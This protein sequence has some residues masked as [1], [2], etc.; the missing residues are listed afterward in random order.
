MGK[1]KTNSKSNTKVSFFYCNI[2][3]LIGLV[4]VSYYLCNKPVKEGVMN[5]N[6]CGGIEAGVHYSETDREP[7]PYVRR[8]FKSKDNNDGE[9]IV[10]EWSGFPCTGSGS[11][12]CCGGGTD[13]TCIATSK[14]GYC[15]SDDSNFIFHRGSDES[16][17]YLK[18]SNDNVIDINDTNDMKNYY[19]K[20]GREEADIDTTP[21]MREFLKRRDENEAYMER[22]LLE[23]RTSR[24]R[25]VSKS[26]DKL[27][28]QKKNI[29]IATWITICH[30]II[31]VGFAIWI[32]PL[33]IAEID[34]F[35]NLI[36]SKYITFQTGD[37]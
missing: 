37:T 6:C 3:I 7:P 9:G 18:H 23:K 13:A 24:Q 35:Y 19:Y 29:Q 36:Y 5:M 20:R 33:I 30:M 25:D 14:G 4:G 34:G 11:G 31:I 27:D 32:R 8:C 28:E 1:S 17:P 22:N 26:R 21:E 15:E 10:Y 16:K 2:L 12:D